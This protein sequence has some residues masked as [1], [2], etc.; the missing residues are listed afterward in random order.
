MVQ[1][2]GT[3]SAEA[4]DLGGIPGR[5]LVVLSQVALVVPFIAYFTYYWTTGSTLG[6]RA[7]DIELVVGS[8]G[9]PPGLSRSLVRALIALALG[10][11]AYVLFFALTGV[12]AEG[13]TPTERMI[14]T[15]SAVVAAA[16]V[17]AKAWFFL[18]RRRQT[19]LDRLFGLVY[20]E[21]LASTSPAA[22]LYQ[23]WLSQRASGS[24][25]GAGDLR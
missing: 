24:G 13:L 2:V 10:V 1:L 25:R 23:L 14:V 21:D 5:A 22:S 18:D 20:V 17:A 15:A 11:A 16:G 7:L 12:P 8:T 4:G 9:E 6:M 3:S 19:L